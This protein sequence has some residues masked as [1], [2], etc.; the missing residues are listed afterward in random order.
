[1]KTII[2]ISSWKTYLIR[3]RSGKGKTTL[4]DIISGIKKP[5]SAEFYIDGNKI[6]NLSDCV[7]VYYLSQ[8]ASI[9]NGNFLNWFD[10]KAMNNATKI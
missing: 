3:G 1:M 2:F 8:D 4:L 6:K 10:R 9:P 7:N 5:N